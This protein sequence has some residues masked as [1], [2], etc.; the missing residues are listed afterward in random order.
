MICWSKVNLTLAGGAKN[1]A[2]VEEVKAKARISWS[3]TI[4]ML[5][6]QDG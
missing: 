5:A 4:L 6:G 2:I 1:M 3:E